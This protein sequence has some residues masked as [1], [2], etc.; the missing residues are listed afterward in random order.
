[1]EAFESAKILGKIP[2]HTPIF[3]SQLRN[4]ML[5]RGIFTL[6]IIASNALGAPSLVNGIAFYV[7]NQPVTLFELYKTM[8]IQKVDTNHA[9]EILIERMLHK[10]EIARYNLSVSEGEID[11]AIAKIAKN[12]GAN[13]AQIKN[14]IENQGAS[15]NE[16]RKE[17]SEQLLKDKLYHKIVS[18]NIKMA[19]E[20]E[21]AGYYEANKESFLLPSRIQTMKYSSKNR[22]LLQRVIQNPLLLPQGIRTESETIFTQK[23]NPQLAMLL[24]KTK[25]G[26]F[27][28]I[29]TIGEDY[30]MFLIKSKE[31]PA[32]IPLEN[33]KELVFNQLMIEREGRVIK[34][35]FEK[36][37]ANAKVNIL[38]L[39]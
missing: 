21:L 36:L 4:R 3:T 28:Q 13:P 1:M 9:L 24:Q 19:D 23:I 7:N 17:H 8:Q 10:E 15:W 18:E 26:E 30:L 25:V 38:R 31:D 11:E 16:Y 14:F 32:P 22:E 6:V 5:L 20:R 2:F 39:Q 34:E 27:T 33:A 35:H 37:R 29:F 12:N